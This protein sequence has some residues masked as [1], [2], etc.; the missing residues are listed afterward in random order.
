MPKNL[1][2]ETDSR[3]RIIRFNRPDQL[4]AMSSAMIREIVDAIEAAD[5]DPAIGAIVVT[6]S[7]KAFMAGADIKEY[8]TLDEVGFKRFQRLG[9]CIYE[10]IER[11]SKPVIA[12]VNGYALGGGFEIALACDVI[13]AAEKAGLG[14]PEINLGLIPGGGGTQR[15][16]RRIGPN[17]AFE[18][19]ATGRHH[20]AQLFFELGLINEVTEG[21]PVSRAVELAAEMA[22][23]SPAALKALKALT[24]MAG[25]ASL[26]SA[27]DA[28]AE[29]LQTLF[30][31]S[32]ARDQIAAFA[33][34]SAA[35]DKE[36]G[37]G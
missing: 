35:K 22:A 37:N 15:L 16:A 10:T 17:K 8:A 29:H 21:E 27:L 26:G 25:E 32:D 33:A 1:I 31:T 13:V 23:H 3:V 30:E 6:G 24:H 34:K 14:L 11:A 36:K 9:R 12:A 5:A 7:G 20:P 4:N 19:L 18:L 28:E 2:I